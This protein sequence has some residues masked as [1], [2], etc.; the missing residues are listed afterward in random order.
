M[1]QQTPIAIVTGA[2]SGI[3][4]AT[5]L[6]LLK[7]GYRVY[8]AARRK[9]SELEAAGG[10]SL[11]LDVTDHDAVHR[12]VRGVLEE[13]GR[14]DALVNS[15]GFAIY[16]A[17]EETSADA[18]RRQFEVNLFGLAEVTKA[19][20]PA[21]RAQRSGKIVNISSVGGRVY[22]PLG[23]WYH[24]SK[25][26]VEGWSDCLRVE[27]RQFGIDVVVVAPGTIK[28]EFGSVRSRNFV[29]RENSPYRELADAMDAVI[30]Q[31]YEPGRS[32]TPETV[33]QV[34][35][36]ALRYRRPKTRYAVGKN[37]VRPLAFRRLLGDRG[38]DAAIMRTVA[39]KSRQKRSPA[40]D[41]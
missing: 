40:T 11:V 36:R 16:G 9:M 30:S 24:A 1:A 12:A 31:G 35:A 7:D 3:G 22:A 5:A 18:A 39:S 29:Q 37:S 13:E 20:L 14:I 28:T 27:V 4:G 17:V 25:H 2:S 33:A 19:V 23:A 41:L 21:M 8:G 6:Q 10:N 32:S 34:I 38:F 15:A 26:A